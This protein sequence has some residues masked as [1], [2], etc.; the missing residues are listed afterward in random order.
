MAADSK[1]RL[2]DIYLPYKPK[3]RTKAQIAREAGLEPLADALLG[4]P[5]AATRRPTAAG[6]V[7]AEQG[8]ADA[9]AAL[10]GAR[11]ILVERFAEDADLIG[12]LRERMWSR[13]PAGRPG[14]RRQGGGRREVLRL[15]RLRRAVHQA[16]LAPDPRDVPRREGGGPRP[17]AWSPTADGHRPR[18][19]SDGYERRDRRPV[20]HRRPGPAGRPVAARHRALGLAHPHPGPPR[21]RPADA[22]VA[23]GRGRGGAGV[24][25]QP[26]R[27]A[28]RRARPAPAR[29]WASTPASAPA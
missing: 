13:G 18:G 20:R 1:A 27:P 4:R 9:A 8:V 12:E 21:H 2:E 19:R 15:L 3:R 24:R 28:A 6:F 23:G 10:D 26:A 7:D 11:A 22:A 17:H 29:R 16:A 14:A 25:R 5:D